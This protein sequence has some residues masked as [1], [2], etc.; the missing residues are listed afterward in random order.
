RLNGERL[1]R[2]VRR[3]LRGGDVLLIGPYIISF[4][5][6]ERTGAEKPRA[7]ARATH[8]RSTDARP[9]AG[10]NAWARPT[11]VEE[12]SPAAPTDTSDGRAGLPSSLREIEEPSPAAPVDTDDDDSPPDNFAQIAAAPRVEEE[13]SRLRIEDAA[14]GG[15]GH[16]TVEGVE[17]LAE[18]GTTAAQNGAPSGG[19]GASAVVLRA[20]TAPPPPA[21]GDTITTLPDDFP[22]PARKYFG[23]FTFTEL[24]LLA[25]GTLLAAAVIFLILEYA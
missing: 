10:E 24:A 11:A 22:S 2:E 14:R 5:P 13:S 18:R 15:E 16:A 6:G 4:V 21:G 19:G 23:R 25:A 3:P 8:A 7:A 12:M 17:T 9:P 20:P 1:A